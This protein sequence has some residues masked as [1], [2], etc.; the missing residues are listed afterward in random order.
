[1]YLKYCRFLKFFGTK[2]ENLARRKKG[3]IT[4]SKEIISNLQNEST[5]L[6]LF[7]QLSVFFPSQ[8]KLNWT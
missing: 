2:D 5:G 6:F 3:E 8:L 4:A 7:L 1:M